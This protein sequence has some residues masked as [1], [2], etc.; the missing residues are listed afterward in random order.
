[1]RPSESAARAP[2]ALLDGPLDE[3]GRA[4]HRRLE[5]SGFRVIAM[6]NGDVEGL[7]EQTIAAHGGINAAVIRAGATALRDC[8]RRD[9]EDAAGLASRAIEPGLRLTQSI[10]LAM[11]HQGGGQIVIV[12]SSIGRY[13]S[14]WFRGRAGVGSHVVQAAVEGALLSQTRQLA[15]EL[16]PRR[17]RVNAVAYGW[18]RGIAPE[19]DEGLS[20]AEKEFLL[21]EISLRRPGKPDEVAAVIA[22]LAGA[23][24]SYVT[25]TVLDVNGGWWMS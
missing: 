6:D 24:S 11:S 7:I 2:V 13:R 22:F 3:I 17:V 21:S 15:F 19:A 1:M 10:G 23:A 16:A 4:A 12:A 14:A 25:G 20:D 18:I 9:G 8:P 5:Q